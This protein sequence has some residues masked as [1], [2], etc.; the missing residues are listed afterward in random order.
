MSH[1][2]H[3][4]LSLSFLLQSFTRLY[5]ALLLLHDHVM[6]HYYY[7]C[8]TMHCLHCRHDHALLF[9]TFILGLIIV[10]FSHFS[11]HS[12]EVCSKRKIS[13]MLFELSCKQQ[14][15]Q[16]RLTHSFHVTKITRI[17]YQHRNF[18]PKWKLT[19]GVDKKV[20]LTSFFLH[21]LVTK[22]WHIGCIV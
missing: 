17:C 8:M 10:L 21:F 7:Y 11:E 5:V 18:A 15:T 14:N 12:S 2:S 20:I 1:T 19:L 22:S 9:H 6:L 4:N 16:S 3:C 13:L